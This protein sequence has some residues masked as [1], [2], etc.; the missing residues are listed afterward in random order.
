MSKKPTL[1]Q[2]GASLLTPNFNASK[3]PAGPAAPADPVTET[4]MVVTLGQVRPYDSNPR[5]K[6][7]PQYEEIKESIR[8]RGLDQPPPITRRPGEEFFIISNGGNTRLA[9]MNEL[10]SETKDEKFRS[11]N[12][13]FRPWKGEIN[14][15]TGHLAENDIR[16]NLSFIER[17]LAIEKVRE[18]YE[19]QA[20]GALSQ[21]ELAKRL[22]ADGY[23]ISNSQISRMQD[24]IR[25]LLPAI[26]NLLY[27]GYG[28][29]P[30]VKL[31]GLYKAANA[32]WG[33]YA[34]DN[35]SLPF[36]DLFTET[37]N[38]FDDP[39]ALPDFKRIQ[40][41]LTGQMEQALGIDYELLTLD[42]IEEGA[43][44]RSQDNV[45]SP[46]NATVELASTLAPNTAG[47]SLDETGE[48]A[49][50][51]V[52]ASSTVSPDTQSSGA[53]AP[54]RDTSESSQG[55]DQKGAVAPII[56]RP[57]SPK[58]WSI[59]L[60]AE[61][62]AGLRTNMATLATEIA[63]AVGLPGSIVTVDSGAGF[64]YQQPGD[65]QDNKLDARAEPIL[66]FIHSLST[67][68]SGR[69]DQ[70]SELGENLSLTRVVPLLL[71]TPAVVD[72]GQASTSERLSD[73]DVI[74]LFSLIR[75]ARRLM[76]HEMDSRLGE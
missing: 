48:E 67:A 72:G 49:P 69:E 64:F 9:I 56:A 43:R 4:P 70:V 22:K 46:P 59:P 68:F 21:R 45:L 29:D 25:Y 51:G 27:S 19:Q 15:L 18:L 42:M 34:S 41:E 11:F 55:S 40:D 71:G 61:E 75:L 14:A 47:P 6:R 28:I 32:A 13:L 76:D 2:V 52:P 16:G 74:K 10:Y 8:T 38:T 54:E 7:N 24:A 63:K 35:A 30:A 50:G 23:K 12:A 31:I 73:G 5:T 3:A 17:A 36:F 62:P 58:S 57:T 1:E 26:P 33:K 39:S 37:L 60:P 44:S 20:G 65:D 66:A 53:S